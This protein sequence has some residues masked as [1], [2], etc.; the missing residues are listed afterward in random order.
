MPTA[1]VRLI[2]NRELVGFFAYS[3]KEDL[4]WLTDQVTDPYQCEFLNINHG[5][6]KWEGK[7]PELFSQEYLDDEDALLEGPEFSGAYIC[8]YAFST[9]CQAKKWKNF[10]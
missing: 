3:T 7:G 4:F 5:G 9:V 6:F 10:K 2:D 8:D 1:F